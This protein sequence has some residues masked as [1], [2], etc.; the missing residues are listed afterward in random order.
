MTK[1][2]GNAKLSSINRKITSNKKKH[3]LVE[4]GLKELK[5]LS[6]KSALV[7][8]YVFITTSRFDGGDGFQDYL[9][10]Q[11]VHRYIKIITN[12]KYISEW[13]SKGLPDE[14]IKPPTTSNNSLIPLIIMVTKKEQNLMEV[15]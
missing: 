1:V 12:T 9:I 6:E 8:C 3:L 13:K 10:F 2:S 7:M 5:K 11:P 4:N 14:S 15:F